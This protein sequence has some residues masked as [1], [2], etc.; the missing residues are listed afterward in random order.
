[1]SSRGPHIKT[2]CLIP[3]GLHNAHCHK[4]LF[5]FAIVLEKHKE[6]YAAC[7]N[8][9]DNQFGGMVWSATCMERHTDLCRLGN[10]TSA[11][12]GSWFLSGAHL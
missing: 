8:V 7:N 3:V 2:A 11:A 1:M 6:F 10:R 12:S 5:A 4:A 9:Q